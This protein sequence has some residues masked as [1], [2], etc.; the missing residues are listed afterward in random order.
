MNHIYKVIWNTIT[1]TWVAVSELSRAKGKTKSSKTLSAVVLAAV[2]AGAIIGDA[3]A[4]RS[5]IPPGEVIGNGMA[6]GT[7]SF[8]NNHDSVAYGNKAQA[9]DGYAVAIGANAVTERVTAGSVGVADSRGQI[10]IGSN[11]YAKKEGDTAIGSNAKAEGQFSTA[12]GNGAQALGNNSSAFGEGA[13]AKADYST[14]LG[15]GAEAKEMYAIALGKE[16]HAE[17]SFST[18]VGFKTEAKGLSS[19]ALGSGVVPSEDLTGDGKIDEDDIAVNRTIADGKAAF[20]AGASAN[21]TGSY[22]SALGGESKATANNAT[23]LGKQATAS[24]DS[25]VAVGATARATNIY[26]AAFGSN[27]TASG[28][29][30]S[31]FGNNSQATKADASAFGNEAKAL[32]VNA[33]SVGAH[34]KV[35]TG[36]TYGSALGREASVTAAN[37]TALGSLSSVT[38][39]NG[40]AVGTSATV[41]KAGGVALG[42]GSAST[43]AALDGKNITISSEGNVVKS[44]HITDDNDKNNNNNDV[45][46]P[47]KLINDPK[48]LTRVKDTI[49]GTAGAVSLGNDTTT[50]QLTNLAP[51]SADSDAV[52]VAQL[53][54]VVGTI[55]HYNVTSKDGDITVNPDTTDPNKTVWDLKINPKYK[56]K[57]FSVKSSGGGNENNDGAKGNNAIAIGKDTIARSQ[58]TIALGNEAIT[59][60]EFSMA[61]GT[62]AHTRARSAVALG[63]DSR[64]YGENGFALGNNAISD[65]N[66]AL[67]LGPNANAMATDAI[68]MGKSASSAGD[69][70]ISIG[71]NSSVSGNKSVAIGAGATAGSQNKAVNEYISAQKDYQTKLYDY[72]RAFREII[73]GDKATLDE[74][75][76]ITNSND[77]IN[78]INQIKTATSNNAKV[79][80]LITKAQLAD[81]SKDSRDQ[82]RNA[83]DI[84]I[85]NEGNTVAIGSGAIANIANGIALGS[86]SKTTAPSGQTGFDASTHDERANHYS[87]L[88][89]KTLTSNLAGLSIGNGDK[90]R[91]INHLAAG[92]EDDDAVNVAQLKSVNLAFKGDNNT[93]GD[94]RLHDQRLSVVGATD[95]FITTKANDNK[96]EINTT[97][98]NELQFTAGAA[99]NITTPTGLTTDKAVANAIN[100]SGW[101]LQAGD[102]TVGLINPGDKVNIASGNGIT[103]TPTTEANGVSKITINATV[104]GI[105]AGDNVTVKTT[106]GVSTINAIDTNTQA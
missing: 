3:E 42:Q 31:A 57:Y 75:R 24:G 60:A 88:N 5:A 49:K 94:V 84:A 22:A 86:E 37:G 23:A 15:K 6:I 20:A 80:A 29:Y 61:I 1:Q 19:L 59:D 54:A 98:S 72:D 12:V 73:A 93:K 52:N 21:A 47:V 13:Q 83:Y 16:S 76:K 9:K 26:D 64:A 79:T 39:E 53:K 95:S 43:R 99:N 96:L 18:S 65:Q 106:N 56:I 41:T 32:E 105:Q 2:S 4:A 67:A 90:T 58:K 89:G 7:G 69:Q 14:A 101:T 17:K 8:A 78:A 45:Y 50:R 81:K 44:N 70:S 34:S 63:K 46:A 104:A 92:K 51:G 10:A 48:I 33:T 27:A 102:K 36:A 82:K 71:V 62:A 25:A 66:S 103:V 85:S 74:L 11:S 91:Q 40:T 68:A 55:K 87:G 30:S 77:A 35:D 38:A 28:S 97:K 100:N